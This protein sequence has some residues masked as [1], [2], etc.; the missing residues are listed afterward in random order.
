M[1]KVIFVRRVCCHWDAPLGS[2]LSLGPARCYHKTQIRILSRV[3]LRY[4]YRG[5]FISRLR[6]RVPADMIS[7]IPFVAT[8]T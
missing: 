6:M 8:E 2:R 1:G 5:E 4:A 7:S 3:P